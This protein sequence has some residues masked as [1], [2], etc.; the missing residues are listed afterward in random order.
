MCAVLTAFPCHHGT[1]DLYI[2][3][4]KHPRFF[5][6]ELFD[7]L[8]YVLFQDAGHGQQDRNWGGSDGGGGGDRGGSGGGVGGVDEW[9]TGKIGSERDLVR[10]RM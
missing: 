9:R 7:F 4:V 10:D 3:M 5:F 1:S 2:S 6:A 8:L